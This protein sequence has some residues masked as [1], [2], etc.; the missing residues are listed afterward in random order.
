VQRKAI[1]GELHRF[2]R[3]LFAHVVPVRAFELGQ[4]LERFFLKVGR[5]IVKRAEER[6][7]LRFGTE[8]RRRRRRL[9]DRHKHP[10]PFHRLSNKEIHLRAAIPERMRST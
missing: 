10:L 8:L 3:Y 7:G 4:L 9:N 2:S 1:E 6:G 5:Q